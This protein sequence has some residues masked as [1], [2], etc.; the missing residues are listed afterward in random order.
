MYETARALRKEGSTP[1]GIS[2]SP[3]MGLAGRSDPAYQVNNIV[4]LFAEAL[5]TGRNYLMAPAVCEDPAQ[6][7]AFLASPQVAE[8]AASWDRLDVAVFGIGGP[9]EDSAV[10]S[11]SFPERY[12]VQMLKC[13][14]VGD[15]LARFFD[16]EGKSISTEADAALLS[17]PPEKLMAIPERVCLAGGARKLEGIRAALR[18]GFVTTLVTDLFTAQGLIGER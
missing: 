14:A 11:S 12:L 17:I 13:H 10:L 7:A 18:A 15:I 5:G 3:L 4:D 9:I 2:I 6:K 8:V 1:P 16:A